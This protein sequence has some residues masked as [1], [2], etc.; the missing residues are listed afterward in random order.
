M[1][2]NHNLNPGE[3]NL[4]LK[5]TLRMARMTTVEIQTVA[6]KVIV[7]SSSSASIIMGSLTHHQTLL[8]ECHPV[9]PG[10]GVIHS[11]ERREESKR[12][13][14]LHQYHGDEENLVTYLVSSLHLRRQ[15]LRL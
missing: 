13:L 15:L 11:K 7:S 8:P 3:I 10:R 4:I 6:V 5:A 2:H 1:R 14:N 12:C 9:G